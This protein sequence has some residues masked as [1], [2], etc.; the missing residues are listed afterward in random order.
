MW[1]ELPNLWIALLNGIG[2]PAAHLLIAW[3]STRIPFAL[4]R[5]SRGPLPGDSVRIYE[6]LFLVRRWKDLLPDAAPWFGGMPKARLQSADTTYLDTFAAETRRGEFSHWLQMLVISA[7]ILWTPFPAALVIIGWAIL[8]NLPCILSLR[9]TRLRILN[10][11]LRI[12]GGTP[13]SDA[14]ASSGPTTRP[15]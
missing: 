4:F 11:S 1:I 6:R 7:F 3:G 13:G 14:T 10:L 2:I 12:G 15:Q 9:H 8:S 5:T